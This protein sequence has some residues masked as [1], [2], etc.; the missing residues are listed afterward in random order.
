MSLTTIRMLESIL[1]T[2]K[3]LPLPSILVLWNIILRIFLPCT[4]I[5][6]FKD[7]FLLYISFHFVSFMYL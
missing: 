3:T 5:P 4:I 2:Q 1:D 7:V 6:T